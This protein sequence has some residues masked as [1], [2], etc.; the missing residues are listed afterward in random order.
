MKP[1]YGNARILRC[2]RYAVAREEA[3]KQVKDFLEKIK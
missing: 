1:G 3:E 2:E